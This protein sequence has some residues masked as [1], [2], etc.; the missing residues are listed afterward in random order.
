MK[1]I[2]ANEGVSLYIKTF[3]WSI[4]LNNMEAVEAVEAE[5]KGYQNSC[6]FAT[7]VMAEVLDNE[8]GC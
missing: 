2:I 6:E 1:E 3:E 5:V 8:L 4:I 7:I